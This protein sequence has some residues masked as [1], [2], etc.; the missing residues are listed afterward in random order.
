MAVIS[1]PGVSYK[2][3]KECETPSLPATVERGISSKGG[4]PL[5]Q[6]LRRTTKRKETRPSYDN[7]RA[8]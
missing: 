8:L 3:K 4:D 7:V 1:L 5:T 6:A 2:R